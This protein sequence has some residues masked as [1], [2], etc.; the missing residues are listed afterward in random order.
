MKEFVTTET[1]TYACKCVVV[2]APY[3]TVKAPEKC[4]THDK[5][6]VQVSLIKNRSVR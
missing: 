6:I 2:I 1:I 4:T 3:D 5:K